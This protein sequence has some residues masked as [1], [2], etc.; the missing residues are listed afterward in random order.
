M[1]PLIPPRRRPSEIDADQSLMAD[2]GGENAWK[3][4]IVR[5]RRDIDATIGV[6]RGMIDLLYFSVG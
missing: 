3:R 4:K 6:R 2:G 5:P 1:I